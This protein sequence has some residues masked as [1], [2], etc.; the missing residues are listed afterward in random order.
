MAAGMEFCLLGPLVVR[1]DGVVMPVQ[2][3]KQ[4]AMLAALLLNAG[5]VVPLEQMIEALWGT[6]P[7]PSARVSVRNYVKRLRQALGDTGRAR[8][9]TQPRGYLIS[10]AAGEL[11]V[12]PFAELAGR[13]Q[14]AAR[15]GSWV[16]A[17]AQARAALALWRG[18]PL[19]DVDSEVLA[20]REVPRLAE[21]R[22]QAL[23][24]RIDADLHLGHQADVIAELRGLIAV[25]PLREHLHALLM[26]ALYRSGR[27][28][29]ALAAYQ[30]ARLV[31]V[32][33]L[34]IE[35]GTGL[36][37]LHQRILTADP[38]L[39]VPEAGPPAAGGPGPVV[40][41]QLPAPVAHFAGRSGELAALTGLLDQSGRE[42]PGTVVI[43]AIGG[44]GGVGK[45]A[46]AVHWAHQVAER[47]PDG[48]L[49][50]NLR[51]FGPSDPV[52]PAAA[53][54][55]FL[56]ALHVPAGQLPGDFAGQQSLYRSLLA[57]RTVLI[58]L[59]N[60]RDGDQV[61][62]LLPGSPGSMV[63]VTSRN[64][65]AG[66]AAAEGA[67]P[68]NLDVFTDAE[69]HELLARRIGPARLAAEPGAATELTALCARLPLALAITAARASA[70]PGFTMAA[71]AD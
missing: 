30:R 14:A 1:F 70:R 4:R 58:V 66:L 45:T 27:Q 52:P 64:E 46:L 26:L 5:Q 16:Q 51:G 49:Y 71:I 65:L 9:S 31:L 53:L 69:A 11:D 48:Q 47:F 35:P 59:D 41:R 3:G 29:E 54:H 56:D 63:V 60:A 19:A 13:A 38:A 2:P 12:T 42:A 20:A 32:A 21:I 8:I 37:G 17:A 68:L 23:E 22:L 36:R 24:A 43:S 25:H 28:G 15:A 55:G 10:V 67:R 39:A 18:E 34:G 44:T 7:P 40:P 50:V 57:D 6:A 61:R 62:P 33:E